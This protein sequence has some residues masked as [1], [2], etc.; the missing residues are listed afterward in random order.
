M[1]L[2]PKIVIFAKS[3][4]LDVCLF[5]ECVTNLTYHT[6]GTDSDKLVHCTKNEVF[7]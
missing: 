1:G 3:S 6:K 7:H 4:A 5:S 2:F